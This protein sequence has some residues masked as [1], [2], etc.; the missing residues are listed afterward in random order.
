MNFLLMEMTHLRY[1]IPLVIEGNRRGI[2]S[3]FHIGPSYKYNCPHKYKDLLKKIGKEYN[4]K[5]EGLD[6]IDLCSGLLFSSEKTGI[7]IVEKATRAKKVVSTYQT[8]FIESYSLYID[9]ADHVLMPSRFIADY[10]NLHTDKNLYLGIPKYDVALNKEQ[11][12]KKYSLP[13]GRKYLTYIS[14]KARDQERISGNWLMECFDQMGYTVLYK[15]RGKDPLTRAWTDALSQRGHYCF[16]DD[17]WYPHTTQEL[18][19]IS[20]IACNFGST[21]IEECVMQRVPLINFDIKPE[22]RNGSKRPHRVTHEYLYKYDYC[23]QV[24]P[25]TVRPGHYKEVLAAA[26]H[27][28][29]QLDSPEM[30]LEFDKSTKNHLF[31]RKDICKKILDVLL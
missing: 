28:N 12:L 26:S 22:I 30:A 7:N 13:T 8:D 31:D 19:E 14:P 4:I 16:T 24:N 11:I 27:L 20:E 21:T 25:D 6:N 2:Q 17:S 18:L 15:T 10:Y 1:W 5:L 9:S 3:T 29:N 23:V